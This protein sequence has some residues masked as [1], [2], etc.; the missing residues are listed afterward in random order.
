MYLKPTPWVTCCVLNGTHRLN[1][2]HV[3]VALTVALA[4]G[5]MSSA[6]AADDLPQVTPE[7]RQRAIGIVGEVLKHEHLWVKVHAAE[8]L[9]WLGFPDG[10]KETFTKELE[11]H[12]GK[13]QYRIGIW[14]VLGRAAQNEREQEKWFG[15]IFDALMRSN[16]PDRS[17]AAETLAKLHYKLR[18]NE[19]SPVEQIAAKLEGDPMV[20]YLLCLL[21]FA[22]QP[23]AEA[24]L[25]NLLESTNADIRLDAAYAIR[26]LPSISAEANKK[27]EAAARKEPLDSA[28]RVYLI[29]AAAVHSHPNVDPSLKAA[30]VEYMKGIEAAKI[31]ACQVLAQI[32]DH[33]D[34][35]M[36]IPLLNNPNPDLRSTAGYAILRI[37]R[38]V[39]H[40]LGFGDWI[41]IAAYTLCL[42]SVGW[43]YS[44]RTKTRE[45]Y[46]LGDRQMRPLMVGISLFA[47]LIS[48][49]SYL[50]LPGEVIKNGPMMISFV[51][52]YPLVGLVVGW[53]I[54]PFIMRFKVTSAYEILELR[55]GSGVRTLGSVLFLSVRLLWMAVIV[56]ATTSKVLVPLL[57]LD[58]KITPIAGTLLA[59]VAIAYTSMGGLRAAVVTDVIQSAILFSAA[60]VT[61]ITITICLGGVQAW[62][63]NKWPNYWPEPQFGYDPSARTTMFSA[64]LAIFTWYVCTLASDQIVVQRYLSTKDAK[65]ARA[66]LFMS[67]AADTV[68]TLLLG[69]VG[70]GLLAYFQTFPHL[71]PDTQ[72]V[73]GDSDKLFSQ[74]IV[75]G[76]PVGLSGLVVAGLL[77]CAMSSLAAGISSTCSVI[78]VDII[79]R[80]RGQNKK[81]ESGHVSQLRY[82]S[83]LVGV[84]VVS[85]SLLVNVVQGNLL[86]IAFKVVNL[87]VAPLAGLFFLAIFVPW[88]RGF[89]ATVGLMCG[90]SVAI[91]ISFWKEIIGTPDISFLWS[92]PLS[93]AAE[94]SIGAL[95]SLVPIRRRSV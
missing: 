11:L 29:G 51:L 60:V 31:E 85:M 74:F 70:L 7:L 20:S 14:R 69:A 59:M 3:L 62:W 89:G 30:L 42:L 40:Q 66:M 52:A 54:I 87:L 57:G 9:L 91:L 71:L 16:S 83:V 13:P 28:A 56:Y 77:A 92:M 22:D 5:G 88:A 27:L 53:L 21:M 2:C 95:V 48:T 82:V 86:E 63:P 15:K 25:F 32:G 94:V 1:P 35:P 72:T 61:V 23:G 43:Y 76:L 47:A 65:A 45:Q 39:T 19:V 64:M 36:L 8:Y 55:L 75:V 78:T 26:H 24:R 67:L 41:V 90:V 34:L 4:A 93:L 50:A 33:S 18:D 17:H 81:A 80:L 6:R 12:G 84:I 58:P 73:L 10:V 44:R 79:D 68:V 37:G 49:I 38:R 46:L